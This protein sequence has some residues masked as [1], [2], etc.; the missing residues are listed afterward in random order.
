MPK[1]PTQA[2]IDSTL[3]GF[4]IPPRPQVL[5]SLSEEMN[6]DEPD[7]KLIAHQVGS[8]VGLSAAVLKTVNSPFFGLKKKISSVTQA[9][10]L[11]GLKSVDRLIT[12]IMLR[13]SFVSENRTLE[14]FWDSAEKA[15]GIAAHIASSLPRGPR[16][17]AYSFGLFHNAGIP[18]LNQRYPDYMHTLRMAT[19]VCDRS[20]TELEDERH[21]VNHATLGYLIAKAWFLPP[22]ICEGI[23]RHH[24]PSVFDDHDEIS[25][26]ALTLIAITYLAEHLNDEYLLLGGHSQWDQMREKVLGH[27]GFLDAE[28]MNLKEEVAALS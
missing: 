11:L 8:D 18:I 13:A 22:A 1:L 5:I 3:K 17:D 25:P 12:S 7:L 15:A 20:I 23:L 28:Y 10:S 2:E 21:A 6:K 24:D 27:L 14:H 26:Q 16:D 19:E 9:V 4:A